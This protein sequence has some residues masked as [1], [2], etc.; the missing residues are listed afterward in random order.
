ML[1]Q[2]AVIEAASW[3][4]E[5]VR[6]ASDSRAA[7]HHILTHFWRLALNTRLRAPPWKRWGVK[8]ETRAGPAG[9]RHKMY[10]LQ[11]A[12][13]FCGG[14]TLVAGTRS[15]HTAVWCRAKR[16]RH[17]GVEWQTEGCMKQV[18]DRPIEWTRRV[19]GVGSD[20]LG[21]CEDAIWIDFQFLFIL[22]LCMR[23]L[24]GNS[25]L[26]LRNLVQRHV[27]K[28]SWSSNTG[29]IF[30]GADN[31][32]RF[33]NNP[34]KITRAASDMTNDWRRLWRTCAGAAATP[35][36]RGAQLHVNICS[37]S[38]SQCR[39][40]RR[41]RPGIQKT[42]GI[43]ISINTQLPH[44]SFIYSF[45]YFIS[46]TGPWFLNISTYNNREAFKARWCALTKNILYIIYSLTNLHL[47]AAL[48]YR[49]KDKMKPYATKLL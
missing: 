35:R 38:F 17:G 36:G 6:L 27:A 42:W 32:H 28:C 49:V 45:I 47:P 34:R 41:R 20:K 4:K 44:L 1:C 46:N 16:R 40:Q 23:A 21:R 5:F 8:K 30:H 33:I 31:P 29:K 10:S 19:L 15:A 18:C 24:L 7:P 2:P 37:H 25:H 11:T 9:S 12:G 43:C 14:K 39:K 3:L 48:Q 26:L 13:F 22:G